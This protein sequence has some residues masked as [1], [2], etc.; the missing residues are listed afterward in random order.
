MRL[1]TRT[2]DTPAHKRQR[3]RAHPPDMLLTTP[4]QLCLLIASEHARVFFEDLRAVII[5]EIH[6]LAP[7]KR[8]D[9]L[10]LALARLRRWAPEHRRIGLSATVAEPE[11][12]ARWLVGAAPALSLVERAPTSR[13]VRGAPTRRRLNVCTPLTPRPPPRKGE[14]ECIVQA[15]PGAQPIIDVL[16]SDARIPWAGHTARHAIPEI[17]AA[18]KRAQASRSSSSTRARK[19]R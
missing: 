1:E 3:Q 19:R 11:S 7:T 8:G 5:D 13:R 14:G 4:E 2:G 16:D 12:L 17:Y 10:A 15:P 6:A 9:L 18:I